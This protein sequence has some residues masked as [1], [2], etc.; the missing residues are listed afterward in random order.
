MDKREHISVMLDSILGTEL[1]VNWQFG[2]PS[3]EFWISDSITI[4]IEHSSINP[5][6]GGRIDL[7]GIVNSESDT[8]Y[9][10]LPNEFDNLKVVFQNYSGILIGHNISSDLVYLTKYGFKLSP[11]VKI[12][13]TM[14][15]EKIFPSAPEKGFKQEIPSLSSLAKYCA[16]D[17]VATKSLYERQQEDTRNLST[18]YLACD[19]I[20][21]MIQLMSDGIYVNPD[22]L[23]ELDTQCQ[24]TILSLRQDIQKI[25]GVP[26]VFADDEEQEEE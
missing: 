18:F 16:Q 9:I 11:E 19:Y 5:Y 4:D 6:L 22:K 1:E 17:C 8:V 23:N 20:A 14:I 15:R 3:K 7:V 26:V 24:A 2:L 25:V 13:D 10:I 21:P 12:Y